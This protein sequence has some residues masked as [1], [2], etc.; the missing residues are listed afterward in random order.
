MRLP[1]LP[2]VNWNQVQAMIIPVRQDSGWFSDLALP[3]HDLVGPNESDAHILLNTA[4]IK[5]SRPI[6]ASI[7]LAV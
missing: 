7:S 2:A 5:P 3:S 1:E 6:R 4:R